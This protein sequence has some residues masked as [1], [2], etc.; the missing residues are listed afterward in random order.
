MFTLVFDTTVNYCSIAL[1][2]NNNLK[3]KF[4]KEMDFGQAETLI[5]EINELLNKNNLV[6]KD[7]SLVGV[8]TGPGSFT[9]V[10]SS[11]SATRA[12]KLAVPDLCVAGINAFETYISELNSNEIADINAV[13]IETKREDFYVQ[14]YDKNH[15]RK[16]IESSDLSTL[17][18][19][20][21]DK[22]LIWQVVDVNKAQESILLDKKRI[23]VK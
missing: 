19:K 10:R 7:L 1:F 14:Y 11:V 17:K 5:V 21:L 22:N 20:V 9:G 15:Q 23:E 16:M 2:E 3:D 12:F 13:I 8:C 6:F 4:E 18:K